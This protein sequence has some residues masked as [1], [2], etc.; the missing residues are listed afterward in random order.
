MVD[1]ADDLLCD[2]EGTTSSLPL[3]FL[4]PSEEDACLLSGETLC[5]AP[6]MSTKAEE[7]LL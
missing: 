7:L 1:Y 3:F 6:S 5:E 2:L 4:L